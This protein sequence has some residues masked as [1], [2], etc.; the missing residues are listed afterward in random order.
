MGVL[1]NK[2]AIVTGGGQ[3]VGRGIALA[4]AREGAATSLMGRT[5][6][7]LAKVQSEIE[8]FGGRATIS[9][10]DVK[11][12]EDIAA[13][14]AHT[15]NSFGGIDILINNA[16]EVPLGRLLDV[17]DEG[18]IDGFL[19]GPLATFRLMKACHPHF[20]ARGGGA[21]VNLATSAAVRWDMSTY[22]A[23][24]AVKQA[25]RALTRAACAEWGADNIRV[26]SIAPHAMSPGM[27]FWIQARPEEA[28]AFVKTIP[29]GR[30]GDCEQ[31]IGRAVVFLVGPDAR[32]LSGATIPLDGGQANFD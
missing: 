16:Q 24:A 28:A 12:A 30:V 7:T 21:V 29:L 9:I 22:G 10:G 27:E 13:A 14:V 2:V 19:S 1:D 25:T 26:N 31:D 15:A 11:S 17:P 6:S 18:F 4:L 32:Y 20:V 8:S 5:R 23:Y 3:G